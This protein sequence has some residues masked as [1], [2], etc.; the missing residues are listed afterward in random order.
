M[1]IIVSNFNSTGF[2]YDLLPI[3]FSYTITGC[4]EHSDMMENHSNHPKMC[5]RGDGQCTCY[6]CTIFGHAVRYL[7]EFLID[8][9]INFL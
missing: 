9:N 8:K 5:H 1:D 7:N 3:P 4:S 6:Y 2:K